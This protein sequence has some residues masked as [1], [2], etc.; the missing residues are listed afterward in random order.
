MQFVACNVTKVELNST[1][2]TVARN[3]AR[4]RES[5][6]RALSGAKSQILTSKG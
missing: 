1:S 2:A 4:K 6:V 5:C 3:I